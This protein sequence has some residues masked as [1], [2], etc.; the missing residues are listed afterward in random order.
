VTDL[1]RTSL[2]DSPDTARLIDEGIARDGRRARCCCS[3]G[4]RGARRRSSAVDGLSRRGE[5]G[6]GRA[7]DPGRILHGGR[8]HCT[9]AN[10]AVVNIAFEPRGTRGGQDGRAGKRLVVRYRPAARELAA[11][12]RPQRGMIELAELSSLHVEITPTHIRDDNGNA[13]RTIG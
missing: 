6:A 4:S 13:L 7:T 3:M 9:G 1:N 11:K 5:R 12:L 2:T 8:S 10:A